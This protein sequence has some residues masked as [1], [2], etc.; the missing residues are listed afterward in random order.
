MRKKKSDELTSGVL[1]ESM[2]TNSA[3]FD[4][5]QAILLNKSKAQTKLQK[6]K[7]E[8]LSLKIQMEDYLK[9][10]KKE[11]IKLAGDFLK[12]YLEILQIR[13]IKFAKYIGIEPSNLN[14]IIKGERQIN[15][16]IA[17]ILGKIFNLDPMLWLEIQSKNEL[18]QLATK[19]DKQLK[20]YSLE[21]LIESI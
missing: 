8:L 17:L 19:K 7:I 5:L 12:S 1:T 18:I 15:S 10:E 11:V 4:Q 13:Q 6:N 16:E 21:D 14:K 2:D 20:K 9:S 3:E